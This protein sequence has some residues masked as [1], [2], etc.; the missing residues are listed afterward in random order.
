MQI[1]VDN[2]F[3]PSSV[4]MNEGNDQTTVWCANEVHKLNEFILLLRSYF[5]RIINISLTRKTRF[6]LSNLLNLIYSQQNYDLIVGSRNKAIRL[7][8]RNVKQEKLTK[9]CFVNY[10]NKLF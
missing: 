2:D 3:L 9:Q 1:E 5:A 10:E 8:R 7:K 4:G 6:L